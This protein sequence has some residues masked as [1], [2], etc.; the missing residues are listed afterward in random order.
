MRHYW[1][2]LLIAANA[3]VAAAGDF[4]FDVPQ[5]PGNYLG[6]DTL[7]LPPVDVSLDLGMTFA[8]IESVALHLTGVQT[9]G[10]FG[11]LNA[12]GE[13]PLAADLLSYATNTAGQSIIAEV[14]LPAVDGPFDVSPTFSAIG[15][16][17]QPADWSDW[18]DGQID[19]DFVASPPLMIATT[20]IIEMPAVEIQTAQLI[21]AGQPE[22]DQFMLLGDFNRDGAVDRL[23]ERVW[24]TSLGASTAADAN[25]SN[26]TDGPDFL[27]WQ[28]QADGPVSVEVIPEP[29][30]TILIILG[31]MAISVARAHRPPE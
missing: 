31:S 15:Y 22:L 13:W 11:D 23:D 19:F 27:L 18:L 1:F 3:A 29:H 10:A 12:P 7:A 5:I 14:I 30:A 21:I 2:G 8:E 28:R 6:D 16:P 20:F 25:G 9:T 17:Q 26:A 4:V 24:E